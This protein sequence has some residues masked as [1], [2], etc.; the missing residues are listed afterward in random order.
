MAVMFVRCGEVTE[1]DELVKQTE[2]VQI[3]L[4]YQPWCLP[5]ITDKKRSG[6]F[7]ITYWM[8]LLL[9]TSADMTVT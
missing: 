1:I 6:H 9:C 3:V 8:N 7:Q 4:Q 5:D 2:R